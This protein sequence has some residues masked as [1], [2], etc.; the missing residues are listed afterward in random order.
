M[1]SV[2]NMLGSFGLTAHFWSFWK[3]ET[4]VDLH[5]DEHYLFIYAYYLILNVT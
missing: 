1:I 3:V 4:T 2:F 5:L